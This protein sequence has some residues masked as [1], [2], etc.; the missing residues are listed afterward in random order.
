MLFLLFRFR[1]R[2]RFRR[3]RSRGYA[4]G[5]II[6]F[7]VDRIFRFGLG[8]IAQTVRRFIE[9]L[10]GDVEG[11]D[12]RGHTAVEDHLGDDLRY[13]FTG[14]ADVQR[15]G[16]VPFDHLRTMTQHHQGRDGAEAAGFQVHGGAVVYLSVD[17][18][19]HQTH[20]LRRQL[21]HG[22]RR[23][24]AVIR[25]VITLPKIQGSLV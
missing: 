6:F 14:D 4:V 20:D 19:V 16:D 25:T 2:L 10:F 18:R 17:D 21:G 15:A 11:V 5:R 24:R 12:R 1:Q 23:H 9:C 3:L 7:I 22:R 13:L 8:F